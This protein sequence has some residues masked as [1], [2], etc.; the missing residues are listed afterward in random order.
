[1]DPIAIGGGCGARTR[2]G[3]GLWTAVLCVGLWAGALASPERA[4]AQNLDATVQFDP[5]GGIATYDFSFGQPGLPV[6]TV[7]GATGQ[8]LF[9]FDPLNQLTPLPICDLLD[10][11]FKHLVICPPP[12][13]L[14]GLSLM[15]Q[16]I[17]PNELQ[18]TPTVPKL[19]GPN[20]IQGGNKA[21]AIQGGQSDEQIN[22]GKGKDDVNPGAGEDDV[23]LDAGNDKANTK[24]GE[25]DKVNGGKGRDEATVDKKDKVKNVEV[26]KRK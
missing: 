4:A 23:N 7:I 13:Q 22:A 5:N 18:V 2:F 6:T 15:L 19:P 24:D 1:M 26:V 11:G 20:V 17:A 21:D 8:Y 14:S 10:P 16:A 12:P 9:V 3:A 25:V